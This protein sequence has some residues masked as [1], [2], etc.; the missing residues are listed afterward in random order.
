[1]P[2]K[3]MVLVG[4]GIS[5]VLHL[6]DGPSRQKAKRVVHKRHK[7]ILAAN[8]RGTKLWIVRKGIPK[9][10]KLRFVGWSPTTD[11][12]AFKDQRSG[13]KGNKYWT[14]SHNDEGGRWPKVFQDQAGNYHY[15][16]GTY[17]VKGP[18]IHR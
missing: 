14:H 8:V 9:K 16:R 11:Y 10:P 2:G 1:M 12:I 17:R 15:A 7:M 5:P 3:K 6:A 4:M 18:W 13:R